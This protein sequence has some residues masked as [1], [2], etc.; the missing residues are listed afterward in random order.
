MEVQQDHGQL[1][2][3]YQNDQQ[4]DH[5]MVVDIIKELTESVKSLSAIINLN[6][7]LSPTNK[8]QEAKDVEISMVTPMQTEKDQHKSKEG[9]NLISNKHR[10]TIS[11]A[12]L[13]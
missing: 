3:Q 7:K 5:K 1:M 10:K 9:Y 6:A 8:P 13:E 11:K 2:L 12:T 4:R